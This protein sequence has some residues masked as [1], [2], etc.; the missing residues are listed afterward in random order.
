MANILGEF[1]ARLGKVV[2][3]TFGAMFRST[4]QPA[5]LARAASKEM[6]RS[7][8]LS[9]EKM[10]V[11]NVYFIFISP[12]DADAL[13]DLAP[14]IEG[15]LETYLMAFSRERDYWSVT[16]PVVRFS[17]DP[18]LKRAGKFD[19]VDQQMTA[20]AIYEELGRVPGVTDD[21]EPAVS[22]NPAN[23]VPITPL[24]EIHPDPPAMPSP[25]SMWAPSTSMPLAGSA[26]TPG[27]VPV[28]T[29]A[30]APTLDAWV[31]MPNHDE[32]TLDPAR[33]YVT[34]RQST[35]DLPISDGNISR[36]HAEFVWNG[37]GWSLRDLG[38]TNGTIL[39]GSKILHETKLHDGDEITF[40]LSTMYYHEAPAENHLSQHNNSIQQ[41]YGNRG[42]V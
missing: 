21:I 25:T 16:R 8:K 13:G 40:G 23:E 14:T 11:S 31:I 42:G 2:E 36:Q 22:A 33:S 18:K 7:R 28:P 20:E 4:V 26:A 35:C 1:E 5:E 37:V 9:L 41:D 3:G 10:Y 15:E 27:S 6:T 12:R 39:N 29:P 30:P 38:S 24:P 32:I 19:I 17:V 34:G